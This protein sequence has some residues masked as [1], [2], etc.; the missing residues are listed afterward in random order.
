[1]VA[2]DRITRQTYS[3]EKISVQQNFDEWWFVGFNGV[4]SEN[5]GLGR[6]YRKRY[7]YVYVEI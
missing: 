7:S 1:M 2:S 5:C 6:K 4:R 3:T